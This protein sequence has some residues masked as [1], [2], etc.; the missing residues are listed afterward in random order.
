MSEQRSLELDADEEHVE[1]HP[2]LRSHIENAERVARKDARL[3]LGKEETEQGRPQEHP[4]NHL[5]DNL[6]LAYAPGQRAD[7]AACAED[8]RHLQEERDRELGGGHGPR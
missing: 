1:T 2:E 6:R 5:A 3:D 4:D 8:H 7:K